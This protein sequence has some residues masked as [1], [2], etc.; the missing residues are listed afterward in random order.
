MGMAEETRAIIFDLGNVIAFFD[1]QKFYDK[2]RIS[3]E[4]FFSVDTKD[5]LELGQIN[6]YDF[7]T[8]LI[9][10]FK[11]RGSPEHI[12]NAWND[13][14]TEN[15]KVTDI[16]SRLPNDMRIILGS[17]T[18]APHID[19]LR[20][21]VPGI[22][23]R[24]HKLVVSYEL[25]VSKPAREFFE[26]CLAAAGGNAGESFYVDDLAENIESAWALGIEGVIYEPSVDLEKVLSERGVKLAAAKC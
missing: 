10:E 25:G 26:A 21:S 8:E 18:S 20:S 24:F 11:L 19:F 4:E 17:A 7:A 22:F 2:A 23:D 6:E 1:L 12:I 14:F 16:I 5:K 13:I 3:R 9:N 15:K